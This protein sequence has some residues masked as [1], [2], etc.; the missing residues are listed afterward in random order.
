MG[1]QISHTTAKWLAPTSFIIDFA[2]QTYGV[3]STPNMVD[4]HNANLSFFSPQ[5]Q[6]I[7]AFFAPQQLLQLVWLYRL[8]T[9]DGNASAANKSEVRRMVDFVPFYALGNICIATWM[10]FWNSSQLRASHVLVTINT[11]AQL[12][13]IIAQQ[14][15]MDTRSRSSVLTHLV[16]KTFAG[17]GVLDFLH[18]G[19]IAFFKD[20]QASTAVKVLTGVGFGAASL[21]SDWIFGGCLV[22]DLI[23]LAVGQR[24]S[25]GQ[26]LGL[27]AL[28]SAVIVGAKNWIR[29]PYD[30]ATGGAD[31]K[32]VVDAG[33]AEER[34]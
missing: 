7:G 30:S 15:P 19:S 34:L 2:A 4:V 27:Y 20:Q 11:F 12:Y 10:I 17:I 21:S 8:C 9:L 23:A 26:L 3:L 28:G 16:S 32:P 14:P 5:P 6:F 25:W 33:E 13:Y 31:Y 1:N 22:Y 18:N 24:G 29:P